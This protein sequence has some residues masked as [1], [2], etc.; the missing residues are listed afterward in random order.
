MLLAYR[1]TQYHLSLFFFHYSLRSFVPFYIYLYL[2]LKVSEAS[3]LSPIRGDTLL[4]KHYYTA[5]AWRFSLTL[6]YTLFAVFQTH[7]LPRNYSPIPILLYCDVIFF[8]RMGRS[9]KSKCERPTVTLSELSLS[10][11]LTYAIR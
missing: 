2:T 8:D 3:L 10:Y 6:G 9:H 7:V 5:P 11:F 1:S 4:K